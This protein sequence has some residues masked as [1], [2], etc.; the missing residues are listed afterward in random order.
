MAENEINMNENTIFE[1]R[2]S[3]E[4]RAEKSTL[5][6]WFK[7]RADAEKLA[8]EYRAECRRLIFIREI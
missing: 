5:I 4:E 2:E 6:Q 3:S 1:V 7:S 8:A